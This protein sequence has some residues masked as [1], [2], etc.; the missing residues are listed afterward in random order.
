MHLRNIEVVRERLN[1]EPGLQD[2][3]LTVK[4][5]IV[6]STAQIDEALWGE[7]RELAERL[8]SVLGNSSY[9]QSA[10][11]ELRPVDVE[12]VRRWLLSPSGALTTDTDTRHRPR[13]GLVF[14]AVEDGSIWVRVVP[15]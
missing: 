4:L 10:V 11:I 8:V 1:P 9:V 14:N 6:G 5:Q 12:R 2:E 7:R 13:R 3:Q 15:R